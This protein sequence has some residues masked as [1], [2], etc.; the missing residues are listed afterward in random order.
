MQT[1]EF[2]LIVPI[3]IDLII[4]AS[5]FAEFGELKTNLKAE[6]QISNYDIAFE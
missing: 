3:F 4:L 2:L 6:F 1:C 5:L